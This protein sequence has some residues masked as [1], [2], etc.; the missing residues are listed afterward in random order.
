MFERFNKKKISRK[1]WL[2]FIEYIEVAQLDY[3]VDWE[4]VRQIH[5]IIFLI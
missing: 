3:G 5:K 4:G 2:R 1:S